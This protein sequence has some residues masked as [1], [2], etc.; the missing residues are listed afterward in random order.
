[1]H[2]LCHIVPVIITIAV[3][4]ATARATVMVMNVFGLLQG[5]YSVIVASLRRR[6]DCRVVVAVVLIVAS[7]SLSPLNWA[8]FPTIVVLIVASSLSL[9]SC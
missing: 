1:M 5:T 2:S 8:R 4:S 3:V 7:L 9:S 6:V